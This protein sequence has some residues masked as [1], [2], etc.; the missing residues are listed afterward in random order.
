[1]AGA[2]EVAEEVGLEGGGGE[3]YSVVLASSTDSFQGRCQEPASKATSRI[4]THTKGSGTL[5]KKGLPA[6]FKK[7]EV[8]ISILFFPQGSET[9]IC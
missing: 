2:A 4:F 3:M 9:W 6:Y 1:V 7:Q 8:K 5:E